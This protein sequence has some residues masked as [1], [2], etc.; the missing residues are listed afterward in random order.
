MKKNKKI[1]II[2]NANVAEIIGKKFVEAVRLD[3]GKKLP[4]AGV[5]IEIGGTPISAIAKQLGVKLNQRGEIIV[6]KNSCTNVPGIFAAGDVTD[7][8]YKQVLLAA[9]EGAAAAFSAYSHVKGH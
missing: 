3:T 8:Q 7:R 5:F 4:L 9:A 2:S 1:E 6:D